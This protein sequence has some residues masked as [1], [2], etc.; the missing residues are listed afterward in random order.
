MRWVVIAAAVV[1][2]VPLLMMAVGL[3]LPAGHTATRRLRLKADPQRVWAVITDF[4]SVPSWWS[5]LSRVERLADVDGREVWRETRANRWSIP[6][7]TVES[8]VPARLV[9]RIADPRLSF[10]GEWCY[11]LAPADG[12]TLLTITERGEV[13]RPALRVFMVMADTRAGIDSYAR[14]LA[15][16]L[17]EEARFEE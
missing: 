8:V 14:A 10:G 3:F 16:R 11:E 6:L 4:A 9:R 2:G 13:R 1:I 12:G 5:Y 7:E 15:R 17:G